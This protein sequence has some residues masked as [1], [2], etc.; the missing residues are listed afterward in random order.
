[1]SVKGEGTGD[2]PKT[3]AKVGHL[4]G[5]THG[6]M[7]QRSARGVQP[8][9]ISGPHWKDKCCL[10]PP[11][12]YFVIHNHKKKSHNA[13][14]EFIIFC[15]ATFIASLGL[16]WPTG[17]GLDTPGIPSS[18]NK[19]AALHER[20]A[21]KFT[22]LD[23]DSRQKREKATV[24]ICKHK[25]GFMTQFKLP[26]VRGQFFRSLQFLHLVGAQAHLSAPGYLFHG[27]YTEQSCKRTGTDL[28]VVLEGRG[29][30]YLWKKKGKHAY[31]PF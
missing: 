19:T 25:H 22:L 9:G 26:V 10:G 27:L 30:V 18:T 6:H 12:K 23:L 15:G 29:N 17:L 21:R 4:I 28:L 16:M 3:P 2:K 5:E 31:C 20:T 13:L 1:M 11:I 24:I 7:I 14:S 8:L